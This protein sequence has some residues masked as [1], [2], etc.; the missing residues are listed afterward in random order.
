MVPGGEASPHKCLGDD[1]S[2]SG[3]KTFFTE[4]QQQSSIAGI[5]QHISSVVPQKARGAK[6][7]DLFKEAKHLFSTVMELWITLQGRHVAGGLNL[8]GQ[9]SRRGRDKWS[10]NPIYSSECAR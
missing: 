6:L 2:S 9:L 1:S 8:A 10:I 7:R 4:S 5:G 3:N